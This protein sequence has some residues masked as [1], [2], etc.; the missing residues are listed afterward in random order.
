[1]EEYSNEEFRALMDSAMMKIEKEMFRRTKTVGDTIR[2]YAGMMKAII[3][4]LSR[5]NP[6]LSAT[7]E[8]MLE[9][10]TVSTVMSLSNILECKIDGF[11]EIITNKED[12]IKKIKENPDIVKESNLLELLK[13]VDV[14]LHNVICDI[15]G[16][17][18]NKEASKIDL[19]F[20]PINVEDIPSPKDKENDADADFMNEL[21]SK[22]NTK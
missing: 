9:M 13:I 19:I 12:F 10:K 3:A 22:F 8:G 6:E 21:F 5:F 18:E 20:N 1:M 7:F 14:D 16:K 17:P 15:I 11:D 4:I 2:S